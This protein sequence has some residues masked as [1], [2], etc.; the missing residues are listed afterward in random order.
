MLDKKYN[1]AEKEAK[2]LNYWKENNIYAFRPDY[3]E[4]FSIDTPPPPLMEKFISVTYSHT[5]KLR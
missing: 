3:R 1:A 5:L 2:W 4:V